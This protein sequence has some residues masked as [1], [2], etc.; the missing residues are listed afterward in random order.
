VEFGEARGWQLAEDEFS[1]EQ[2]LTHNEHAPQRWRFPKPSL[3]Y[4][5]REAPAAVVRPMRRW[6]QFQREMVTL[7]TAH[8]LGWELIERE[9]LPCFDTLHLV[10]LTP[11][12]VLRKSELSAQLEKAMRLAP[13]AQ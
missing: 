3:F 8:G 5:D 6:A 12:R 1:L 4:L 2:L 13:P 11:L 10:L 7:L 9:D